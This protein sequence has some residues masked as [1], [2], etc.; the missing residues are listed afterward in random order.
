MLL[1]LIV[2]GHKT[3]ILSMKAVI[4]CNTDSKLVFEPASEYRAHPLVRVVHPHWY[5]RP[6]VYVRTYPSLCVPAYV[7]IEVRLTFLLPWLL[8]S[9]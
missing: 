6:P 3:N 9:P 8:L 7:R 5:A 2:I 1:V 4:Q